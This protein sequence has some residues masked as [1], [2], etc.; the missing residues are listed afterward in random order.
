MKVQRV[1]IP[2]DLSEK[3]NTALESIDSF[4]EK[5]DCVVDVMHVIPLSRYLNDSFDRLGIPL[6]MEK[7]VYPKL[8]ENSREE[9]NDFATKHIKHDKN[10]GE[11]LISID[12]KPSDA[13]LEQ[14]RKKDYDLIMMSARGAHEGEFF[15]GSATDKII[16][17]SKVPVLTLADHMD[18]SNI[19]TI[20]VPLDF[21]NHSLSAIPF[22]FNLALQFGARLEL[23][24]VIELYAADIQGIEPTM[25]GVDDQEVYK[26]ISGQVRTFFDKYS[27]RNFMYTA[28]D[29]TH[30]GTLTRE[31]AGIKEKV[32]VKTVVKKGVAAHHEIIDYANGHADLLV[33]STHGRSGLSRML[34]G[35]TTEQVVQHVN[36]PQVTIKS[37]VED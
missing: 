27:D 22:A 31:E 19:K 11:V 9:L 6:N 1:L 12:R 13:I 30:G 14:T 35:S 21:S 33:M 4:I 8:I 17:H 7:E 32:E 25:T 18:V 34:I 28:Q 15:H 29:E 36:K 20:V 37:D 16:R 24:H 10:K 23:L 2:T 26:G 5:F 3:S